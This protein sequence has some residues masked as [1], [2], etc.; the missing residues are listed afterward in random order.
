M[1][2]DLTPVVVAGERLDPYRVAFWT[3]GSSA[4]T[5][6]AAIGDE[7]QRLGFTLVA[8]RGDELVADKDSARLTLSIRRDAAQI[9][10]GNAKAYPTVPPG[11]VVA[12]FRT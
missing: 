2:C 12:E 1:P 4:E 10:V 9:M 7:L 8:A 3:N 11:S 6:M 5:V